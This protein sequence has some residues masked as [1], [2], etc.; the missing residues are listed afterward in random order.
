MNEFEKRN[1]DRFSLELPTSLI[2]YNGDRKQE[3]IKLKTNNVS[4]GGAFFKTSKLLSV[5][6]KIDMKMI[7]SLERLKKFRKKKS[8]I[9]I[10]GSVIRTDDKG[11][12]ICFDENYTI[13][14]YEM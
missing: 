6:T 12:A 7:V 14:P 5:G 9:N 8:L 10:S 4:G 13:S 11:F 2:V 1:T 3:P